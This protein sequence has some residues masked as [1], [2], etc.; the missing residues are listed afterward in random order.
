MTEIKIAAVGDLLINGKICMSVKQ[1]G[2][3]TY[4]F[5]YLFEEVAPQLQEA[6]LT[7]GNLEIPLKGNRAFI[8]KRNPKTGCPLFNAPEE[9]AA[10][11][12]RNGFDVL[13]TANN[14]C[15]DNG[16]DGL[17]RTLEVLDENH[18]A[19]TGTFASR[20]QSKQFLIMDVKGIKV[21]ILS[22]TQGTNRIAIPKDALWS[23]NLINEDKMIKD[24]AEI[25]PLTDLI[26]VSLHFGNEYHKKP[27]QKQ[28]KLV[29]TLFQYGADI[30]LGSHPHVLQPLIRTKS[31]KIAI[32][33]LGNFISIR[34]RNNPYTNNG[35][36]L[37]LRVKKEECSRAIITEVDWV[38][39][40]TLRRFKKGTASYRILPNLQKEIQLQNFREDIP[41][42]DKKMME[43]MHAYTSSLLKRRKPVLRKKY[44]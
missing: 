39:T 44:Q 1:K 31:N 10:A 14:H 11:L 13:S 6:D 27:D 42:I 40:W 24:L 36:I 18:L 2:K 28:K 26:I 17:L 35:L 9:L 12:K 16:M 20:D 43:K 34:L 19:H 15:L 38:P 37:Q 5:D 23:I 29:K 32:F 4:N 3:N 8:K 22:Y 30:I 25:K 7:L 41:L 21:G 33:S